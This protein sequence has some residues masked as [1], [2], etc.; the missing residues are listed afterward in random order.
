MN[1]YTIIIILY[2]YFMIDLYSD[3]WML[4]CYNVTLLQKRRRVSFIMP[5][6]YR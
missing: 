5:W 3:A 1:K 4:P 2:Y 6:D